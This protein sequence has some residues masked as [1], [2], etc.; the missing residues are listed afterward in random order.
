MPILKDF[1]QTKTISLPSWPDSKVEIYDSLLVGEVA[2]LNLKDKTEFQVSFESLPLFIKSWNFT[3]DAG[4]LLPIA[5]ENITFLKQEDLTYFL[6]Q[7][8]SFAKEGKKKEKVTP[9][10]AIG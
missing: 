9:P 1:R 5:F 7:I 10:S 2:R 3:D 4:K 6:D 8:N